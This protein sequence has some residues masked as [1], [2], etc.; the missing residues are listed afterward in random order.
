MEALVY[1]VLTV[2]GVVWV[3]RAIYKAGNTMNS[4]G[5][6]LP[7]EEDRIL[8]E[9]DKRKD[10]AADL[11]IEELV[12]K[13]YKEIEHYPSWMNDKDHRVEIAPSIT[14]AID[15]GRENRD[16]K[17]WKRVKIVLK[18]KEY[19]FAFEEH[20]IDLPDGDYQ[21]HGILELYTSDKKVAAIN[22]ARSDDEY[23]TEWS[24]FDTKA[25]IEGPWIK[26]FKALRAWIEKKD[27]RQTEDFNKQSK[28]GFRSNEELKKDFGIG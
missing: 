25:F 15:P 28:Y 2:V 22:M 12:S 27:K 1:F 13:V 17:S 11:G 21:T 9:V 5:S 18:E 6:L 23:S 14:S 26:D 7:T 16:S 3:I 4:K 24:P 19:I 20:G 8:A 10:R